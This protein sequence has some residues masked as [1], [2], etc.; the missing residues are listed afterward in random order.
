M[1]S[2]IFS[3]GHSNLPFE[4][5]AR[6]LMDK[7]VSAVADVRS[8]PFSRHAP[9]FSQREFKSGLRIHRIAY[10]FFGDELG[11]RPKASELFRGGIADYEEMAKTDAFRHGIARLLEG[12]ERHRIAMI[13]SERDP[14]HCHRCLLV[15]RQLKVQGI[16]TSHLHS[17]GKEETQDEV[18]ERLLREENLALE[19]MLRPRAERLGEAYLRR[20]K[21]A[22]F[23]LT[24]T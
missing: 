15:G 16:V 22:A 11:G 14:L 20:N 23:S 5:F 7:N 18:E 17:D 12:S 9:W 21:K 6:L 3:L 13:C 1:G 24:A 19:D 8:S 2:E 4:R 10:S